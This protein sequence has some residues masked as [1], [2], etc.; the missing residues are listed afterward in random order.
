MTHSITELDACTD[1]QLD[2]MLADVLAKARAQL[3]RDAEVHTFWWIHAEIQSRLMR[4]CTAA[5]L[6]RR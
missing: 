6:D 4:S 3:F 2:Q 5:M 1:E